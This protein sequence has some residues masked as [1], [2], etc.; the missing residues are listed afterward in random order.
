MMF[1]ST[2][3]KLMNEKLQEVYNR[4]SDRD[5]ALAEARERVEFLE[6]RITEIQLKAALAGVQIIDVPER[7]VPDRFIKGH[8]IPAHIKVQ[9]VSYE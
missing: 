1:Q 2:H 3:E 8:T 4:L 7:V 5:R 6:N 9:K